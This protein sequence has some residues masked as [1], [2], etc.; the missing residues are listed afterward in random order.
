MA[1]THVHIVAAPGK[2][3]HQVSELTL[4]AAARN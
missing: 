3:T 1:V 4:G 2:L